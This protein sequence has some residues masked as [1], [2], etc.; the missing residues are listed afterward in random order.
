M[1]IRMTVYKT[2]TETLSP[3]ESILSSSSMMAA[4]VAAV[5]S[6]VIDSYV[7]VRMKLRQTR[8]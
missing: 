8:G 6:S 5:K 4:A 7:I 1:L 2:T 3:L